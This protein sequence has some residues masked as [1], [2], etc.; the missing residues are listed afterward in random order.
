MADR[1]IHRISPEGVEMEMDDLAEEVVI[2]IYCDDEV[3]V[4]ILATPSDLEDLAIGHI[5]C[6]CRGIINSS[7]VDG[8]SVYLSGN[9]L[10]RPSGDLLTAACGACTEGEI[11]DVDV[12]VGKN[13]KLGI[14]PYILCNEMRGMQPVFS[15]TGGV[16][17]AALADSQQVIL[18]REDIGRHNAVD[19]VIGA[20][21]T[22]KLVPSDYCLILSGRIG[23]ELV[24]KAARVGI[25]LMIS[26]GAVSTAAA[27]LARACGMTL[28]GF[29]SE[30]KGVII[31]PTSRIIDKLHR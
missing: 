29:T 30:G 13:F 16:H 3:V 9:V 26:V 14:E 31:G 18:V 8:N 24:A 6:E 20:A 12:K 27:D 19:K 11:E 4:R 7:R 22:A 23:W 5:A 25:E 17:A 1:P 28:V 2:T 15:A 21:I 10:K